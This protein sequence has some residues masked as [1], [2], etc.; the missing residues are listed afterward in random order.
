[1]SRGAQNHR[2]APKLTSSGSIV[3]KEKAQTTFAKKMTLIT[4]PEANNSFLSDL[5]TSTDNEKPLTCGFYRQ[6]KGDTLTYTYTYDEM[7][8]SQLPVSSEAVKL[9]RTAH[10]SSSRE[11]STFR[12]A[13]LLLWDY[14][15]TSSTLV[16][17]IRL[18]QVIESDRCDTLSSR[19]SALTIF[20]IPSRREGRYD[21]LLI[22]FTRSRIL[23]RRQGVWCGLVGQIGKGK[24]SAVVIFC[25]H[26][27]AFAFS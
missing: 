2:R 19:T 15:G 9:T 8:V 17:P 21:Y 26:C 13:P 22:S 14:Q 18:S 10:S 1:M 24:G 5:V 20:D 25:L 11:S 27:I 6:L 16:S 3:Y 12:T 23:L 7:K 4:S